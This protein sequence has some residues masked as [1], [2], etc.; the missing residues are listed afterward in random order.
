MNASVSCGPP[1]GLRENHRTLVLAETGANGLKLLS[2]LF[3]RPLVHV[4]LVSDELDVAF[5]TANRLVGRFEELRLLSETTGQRRSRVFDMSHMCG[6]SMSQATSW[7][8]APP[9]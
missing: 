3:Q 1:R 9:R 8:G 2:L 5:P 6:S 4:N 7:I